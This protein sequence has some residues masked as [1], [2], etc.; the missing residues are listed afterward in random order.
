MNIAADILVDARGLACP[1]PLVK[2][3]Q[4]LMVM[5]PGQSLC[6]LATDPGARADIDAFVEVSGHALRERR[7]ADGV[8]LFVLVKA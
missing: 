6:L 1:M 5:E 8:L 2:A 7:E 4:A 3:R